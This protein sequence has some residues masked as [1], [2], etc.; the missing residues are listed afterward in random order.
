M[1]ILLLIATTLAW[2]RLIILV[3]LIILLWL[4]LL[5]LILLILVILMPYA[6]W[7]PM[8]IIAAILFMVA[9]NMSEWKKFVSVCKH[10]PVSDILV[11]VVTFVLT[12]I[13]DLVIAIEVG[14][15]FAIREGG[16]TVGSGVVAAIVD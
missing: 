8:P 3:I 14:L 11:M 1:L 13:F 6:A 15:R 7:I 16:R 2:L 12:V 9:Y 10:A 4:T 5:W